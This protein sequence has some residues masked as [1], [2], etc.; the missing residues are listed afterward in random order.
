MH[1][2]TSI[3]ERFSAGLRETAPTGDSATRVILAGLL[4]AA[5]TVTLLAISQLINF[6]VFNLRIQAFDSD[7]HTSV[8]GLASLA[9]Q[10]AVGAAAGWRGMHAERHRW[11]WFALG[12]LVAVLG[13]VREAI[14]FNATALAVPLVFVFALICW[15]TWRDAGAVRLIVWTGL[16]LMVASLVLHKVGIASDASTA[17][18]YTWPYQ[19]V[20]VIKHG[21]EL[22]GWTLVATGILAG[23]K[24]VWRE[25]SSTPESL[26][27]E[28][29]SVAP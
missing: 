7:Y 3:Q 5:V 15:L 22:A 14:T 29:E 9:A 24:R 10:L 13:I 8:F 12:A 17:S 11:A 1:P 18:D 20:T 21:C 2:T 19:I 27:L 16:V 26:R 28:M 23:T 6:G 25:R 4:V